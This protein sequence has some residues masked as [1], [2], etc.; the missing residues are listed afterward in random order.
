MGLIFKTVF[1]GE[2]DAIYFK[3]DNEYHGDR[4]LR[5]QHNTNKQI[6]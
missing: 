1:N 5:Q 3:L 4:T 6:R 2:S